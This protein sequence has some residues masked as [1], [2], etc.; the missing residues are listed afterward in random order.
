[1][2]AQ[3]AIIP[4]AVIAVAC[5]RG[6]R[7]DRPRELDQCRV[8]SHSGEE[9]TKCLAISRNWRADSALE[10]GM[11]FQRSLDSGIAATRREVDSIVAAGM[12]R[13][14][15]EAAARARPWTECAVRQRVNAQVPI[16]ESVSPDELAD[17]C[18]HPPT[19]EDFA[20]YSA[21]RRPPLS[22]DVTYWLR[23]YIPE[24]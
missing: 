19:M 13:A 14:R 15:S 5:A 21:R 9:L 2:N 16:G 6:P 7:T 22:D 10:E 18:G 23:L 12:G 3:A 4:V 17:S 8:V 1:M 24:P 20:T 11:T